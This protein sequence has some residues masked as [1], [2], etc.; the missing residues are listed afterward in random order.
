M[1][2]RYG[3]PADACSR[4][5]FALGRLDDL[6]IL[7]LATGLSV[8]E[9]RDRRAPLQARINDTPCPALDALTLAWDRDAAAGLGARPG[10]AARLAAD[11]VEEV[12]GEALLR[13]RLQGL[14]PLVSAAELAAEAPS[15]RRL[16]AALLVR[17]PRTEW[18]RMARSLGVLAA[19]PITEEETE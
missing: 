13:L 6:R 12:L 9:F 1:G 19:D 3:W 7:D 5:A 14:V 10:W 2:F 4:R 11:R 17:A 15:G 8:L 18:G 16:V